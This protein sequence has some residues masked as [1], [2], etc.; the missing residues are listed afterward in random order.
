MTKVWIKLSC[1]FLKGKEI[2]APLPPSKIRFAPGPFDPS[3]VFFLV[4]QGIDLFDSTFAIK[5]AEE[6][7]HFFI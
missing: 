5:M 1:F 7:L 3:M 4:Q 2:Q 6:V